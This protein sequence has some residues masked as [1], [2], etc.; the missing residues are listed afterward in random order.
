[1]TRRA[2][3]VAVKDYRSILG[4]LRDISAIITPRYS[5]YIGGH[6]WAKPLFNS[7]NIKQ[8]NDIKVTD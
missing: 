4:I 2:M 1:M 8:T 7:A 3:R 5:L 6:P